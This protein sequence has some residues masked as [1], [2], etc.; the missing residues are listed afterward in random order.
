M[1]I[2]SAKR[3]FRNPIIEGDLN[4]SSTTV[5]MRALDSTI[6]PSAVSP[7]DIL[8]VKFF[9]CHVLMLKFHRLWG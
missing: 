1:L 7:H 9:V 6:S 2:P 3:C 5:Y 4:K 8:A